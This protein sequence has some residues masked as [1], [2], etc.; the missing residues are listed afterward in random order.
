MGKLK[1]AA[2]FTLAWGIVAP[3]QTIAPNTELRIKLLSQLSTQ[4]NRKGDKIAAQVVSPAVFAGSQ[5]EGEVK[6]SKS[7]GKLKGTSVLTFG[8][9]TIVKGDNKIA[10]TSD[11]KGFANSQ[12][13]AN[14]DE[15]GRVLEKKNQVGKVAALTGAGALIGALAGGVKAAAIGAGAGAAAAVALIEVSVKAPNIAFAPG[16]EFILSVSPPRK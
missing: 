6:E 3:A 8:F 11:V 5:M 15:E 9:G 14:V 16:S 10:V 13:K 12:G 4:T 2:C 1:L 7:G